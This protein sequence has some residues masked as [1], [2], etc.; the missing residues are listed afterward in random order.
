MLFGS[1]V[2]GV[3]PASAAPLILRTTLLHLGP[4][5]DFDFTICPQGPATAV[6]YLKQVRRNSNVRYDKQDEEHCKVFH[7]QIFTRIRQG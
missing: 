3:A 2:F 4:I 7:M 5:E 1:L 6:P